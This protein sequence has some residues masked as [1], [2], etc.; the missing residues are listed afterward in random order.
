MRRIVFTA[1]LLILALIS[2]A[3]KDTVILS[4]VNF[5]K[6]ILFRQNGVTMLTSFSDMHMYIISLRKLYYD[7]PYI[8]ERYKAVSKTLAELAKQIKRSDTAI[9]TKE[10]IDRVGKDNMNIFL[11]GRIDA[12]NIIIIDGNNNRQKKIISEKVIQA[13]NTRD[14]WV[15]KLYYL[16]ASENFFLKS[17][18]AYL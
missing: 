11:G 17:V 5:K 1:S 8:K 18:T 14:G 6:L 9:I 2:R 3:L 15:G 12:N 7:M 10:Q 16:P 13:K 4:E